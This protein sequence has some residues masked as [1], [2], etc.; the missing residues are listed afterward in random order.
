MVALPAF[1]ASIPQSSC[2]QI[3]GECNVYEG[4]LFQDPSFTF[5][6][7]DVVLLDANGA[8]SDVLRF[9]NNLIDTGGGTGLGDGFLEFAT[10]G[11][12]S[13]DALNLSVN[14]AFI[15]KSPAVGGVS[16]TD[17]V[18]ST[19]FLFHIYSSEVPEASAVALIG[20]GLALL[21][22]SPMTRKRK[23]FVRRAPAGSIQ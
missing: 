5:F 23:G 10:P 12:H 2:D 8:S 13:P 1:P 14:A 20:S 16:V 18:G 7:G 15:S 3:T 4:S 11:N 19:G 22:L 9:Y 6:A 21:A 17:Y